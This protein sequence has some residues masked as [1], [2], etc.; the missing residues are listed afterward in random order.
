MEL[1][2]PPE[3]NISQDRVRVVVSDRVTL[4]R[5]GL[6]TV[7]ATRPEIE[8]VGEIAADD[9]VPSSPLVTTADVVVMRFHEHVEVGVHAVHRLLVAHPGVRVVVIV[10][11]ASDALAVELLRMG[12]AGFLLDDATAEAVICCVE[13]VAAGGTVLWTRVADRVLRGPDRAQPPGT[14]FDGL[15]SRE[16]DIVRLLASGLANK[17]IARRLGISEKT[18]HNHVTH[19]YAKL[20]IHARAQAVLYAL[21]KGLVAG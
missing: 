1:L 13:T 4:S 15:T 8:V 20:G 17:Q 7:L 10:P 14:V 12:V 21:G 18:V 3:L 11:A 9:D 2:A 16:V 5:T 6:A 19:C